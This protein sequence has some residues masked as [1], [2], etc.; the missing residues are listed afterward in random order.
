MKVCKYCKKE[1]EGNN[2]IFANHIR[3]CDKN[4]E[5]G[6]KGVSKNRESQIRLN[7]IRFGK[8]KEFTVNCEKCKSEIII[9]EPEFQF[10]K[11]Q[12]Y[13][14]NRSCSN[15]RTFNL[16]TKK[17]KSEISK[18]KWKNIDYAQRVIKNN[19]DRNKIFSSKGEEEIRKYFIENFG[20]D[21]WTFGGGFKFENEILTRDLY[22][23]KL[24]VIFEYDGIW[25]F[26]DIH[27]QLER[28]KKKDE[29]LEKWV[30]ENGWRL[31]RLKEDIYK[32]DKEYYIKILVKSIYE[33]TD[34]IIKIY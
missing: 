31:V 17:L 13:Y 11:K 29:L 3:W 24:K 32:M 23:N 26:K 30:F 7:E 14:C 21:G 34:Q 5:N 27:G 20:N 28:K 15:S 22:S 9:S 2:S 10:P 12:K 33:K 8:N 25:H 16:E 1:I 19:I 4:E 6:D 18:E